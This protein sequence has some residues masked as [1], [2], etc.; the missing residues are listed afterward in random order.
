[1]TVDAPPTLPLRLADLSGSYNIQMTAPQLPRSA[2]PAGHV[3][4]P[5]FAGVSVFWV[6]PLGRQGVCC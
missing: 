5:A 6:K 2:C 3:W 1:M 4:I